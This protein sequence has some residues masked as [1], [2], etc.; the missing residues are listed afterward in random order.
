MNAEKYIGKILDSRYEVKTVI[1]KGGSACVFGA[2]DKLLSR[3]VALKIL[4]DDKNE[5]CLNTKS[6]DTE[7]KAISMLS[8]PNVVNVYD[9]SVGGAVKYIVME[10]V[11]GITLRAYLNFSEADFPH[12]RFAVALNHRIG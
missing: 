10:H 8:H 5:F 7:A 9:I 3:T 12:N 1:G 6:F 4:E 2:E 11:E